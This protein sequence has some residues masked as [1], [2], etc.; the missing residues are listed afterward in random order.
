[1]LVAPATAARSRRNADFIGLVFFLAG[2]LLSIAC[3]NVANLLLARATGRRKEIAIRIALGG[4]PWALVRQLMAE[5]LLLA[6]GGA[7]SGVLLSVWMADLLLQLADATPGNHI[8]ARPDWVV[9]AFLLSITCVTAL[10]FG[11][12]PAPRL[13]KP[14]LPKRS[15]IKA[16]ARDAAV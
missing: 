7:A 2:L 9:L 12:A 11:R 14:A 15:R 13:S 8:D 3:A 6:A 1:M 4:G 5:S 16:R 10:L